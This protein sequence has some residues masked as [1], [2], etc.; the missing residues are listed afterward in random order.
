MKHGIIIPFYSKTSTLKMKSIAK[1][2]DQLEN[3]ALC[4]VSD[5]TEDYTK[6]ELSKFEHLTEH[7]YYIRV[8]EETKKEEAVKK[9][10]SF[11]FKETSVDTIGYIDPEQSKSFSDYRSLMKAYGKTNDRILSGLRKINNVDKQFEHVHFTDFFFRI[12]QGAVMIASLFK[13]RREKCVAKLFSRKVI[14][15]LLSK[16]ELTNFWFDTDLFT[17][18]K[19][20][21]GWKR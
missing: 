18:R 1:L 7:T 12:L 21:L 4:F 6:E 3:V 20:Q 17:G 5:G 2:S 15:F 11:L 8:P 13:K 9:A 10:I 16:N 14:P 19:L